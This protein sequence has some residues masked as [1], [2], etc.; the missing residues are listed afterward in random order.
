[1]KGCGI[2]RNFFPLSA[3][4]KDL[5]LEAR[6]V[7]VQIKEA[8]DEDLERQKSFVQ[9]DYAEL[10]KIKE[11]I[12][13]LSNRYYQLIPLSKY[14]FA[15]PMPLRNYH[16]I[17][18][19]YETLQQLTNIEF[20][21]KILLGAKQRQYEMNPIDYV[22]QALNLMI[23]PLDKAGGE[24]EVI[25]KYIQNTN[26]NFR[27]RIK[28]I[29]K[30]QRKGEAEV[31]QTFKDLPNHYLL[32]HGSSIFNFIGILAQGLRIAPPEAPP[33]GYMFGKGVY[34]ADMF[35][36]S[37]PYANRGNFKQSS[38]LMLLCEV[39]LGNQKELHNAQYIDKLEGEF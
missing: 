9:T 6:A 12:Y 38:F 14:T 30:I 17:Q 10:I 19:Q 16:E 3:I 21:S 28:N 23:E 24:Y 11:R 27:H 34:F 29:F 26:T 20:A 22:H 7:L 4:S 5:I 25:N 39:A 18:E 32:Y 15:M 13:E 36:K 31:M 2:N 37:A 8:V 33:T 1:M 35:D